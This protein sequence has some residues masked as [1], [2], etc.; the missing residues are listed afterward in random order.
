YDHINA[1]ER[2]LFDSGT[3]ILKFYLHISKDEQKKRLQARLDNPEK[4]WK[5]DVNDLAVRQQWD[6]Y[7][8]AYEDALTRCNTDY[9][10]WYIVPANKKW[11]RDLVVTRTIVETLED[12]KLAYP[13]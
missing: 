11:Y 6:A 7:M 4:H 13:E 2:L 8:R 1:F 5:F 10:P 9:A 3:R 12:M